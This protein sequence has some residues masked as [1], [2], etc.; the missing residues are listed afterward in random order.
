MAIDQPHAASSSSSSRGNKATGCAIG[1]PPS[2]ASIA[3]MSRCVVAQIPHAT[4][5]QLI[6]EHPRLGQLLWRE[7]MLDSAIF[8]EW[9]VNL[10]ARDAHSR[11]AHLLCELH[12]R[13]MAVGLSNGTSF[14]LPLTQ[15]D[16]A[17]AIGVSNVHVGRLV[18]LDVED[19]ARLPEMCEALLANPLIEDYEILEDAHSS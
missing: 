11:L 12:S 8:R 17:D 16:I 1:S 18:E 4:V 3:A 19:P 5:R 14:E 7:T 10:G 6:E 15:S 13:M 2:P 9:V